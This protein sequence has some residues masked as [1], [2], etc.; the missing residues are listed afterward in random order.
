MK[1]LFTVVRECYEQ[2]PALKYGL[3]N[4]VDLLTEV[5]KALSV[6]SMEPIEG[7]K[8]LEC[9]KENSIVTIKNY[10]DGDN[11]NSKM[12][13]FRVPSLQEAE[14]ISL[15]KQVSNIITEKLSS[16]DGRY[17][18]INI[19]SVLMASG[20]DYKKIGIPTLK[21]F[22]RVV[23][24]EDCKIEDRE[25]GSSF[26]LKSRDLEA[27]NIDTS[28][29]VKN[30]N[31]SSS[32]QKTIQKVRR[33]SAFE[34]L[35]NF[36][37]FPNKDGF[38]GAIRQ[39][40]E[41]KA[42]KEKWFYGKQ[43][44]GNYPILRRIFLLTFER[45]LAEDEEH[46]NDPTWK[47]KIRTTDDYAVFNTGLV[48]NLYEP[49]YAL[50]SKNLRNNASRKWAFWTFVKSNDYEHQLLTR[51]FGSDLPTPAHYYNSTSE[52][53]YNI[54]KKIGSYNWDHFMDHCERLPIDFLKDNGPKF[55]YDQPKTELFFSKLAEAIKADPR[56][57]YR[58]KK[59]IEDAIEH[60]IKRVRWN[61]K[62]AIPIYYPGQKQI[63]LLLPLALTDEET[64][65]VALVLE[66][67]ES[68]AYIAHTILTL[69]MAYVNARLITRPDSDW[70]TADN[71][72]SSKASKEE[73]F[74]N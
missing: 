6:E 61:F 44:P 29:S 31:S 74:E 41:E 64:I 17:D 71:I 60:S 28:S 27:N 36:A 32:P 18:L 14:R 10:K 8:L 70:L 49:V 33:L 1:E 4:F 37:I 5:N 11:M 45:L 39:L 63:S 25:L 59:R 9:I 26:L 2:L 50:F 51:N 40:A 23:F 7:K 48:D 47:K 3:K 22:L 72:S 20:V 65:D 67:T 13:K 69:R 21:L 54:D 68:D 46:I 66:A 43:D 53:V 19:G 35:M 42:L 12:I 73:E 16:Q 56:S 58:I 62:T 57:M 38:N 24:Q 55:D 30:V 15:K 52:L 34:K